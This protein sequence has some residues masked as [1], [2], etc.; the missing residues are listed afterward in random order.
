MDI[1]NDDKQA[2]DNLE[3][4]HNSKKLKHDESSKICELSPKTRIK[5]LLQNLLNLIKFNLINVKDFRQG[6]G[7][8]I[9]LDDKQKY[10]L[11]SCL[12]DKCKCKY[13]YNSTQCQCIGPN[14]TIKL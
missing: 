12:I 1:I 4:K 2:G 14:I 5:N 11:I 6:P 3:H 7:L 10:Y 9:I 8:S 13:S